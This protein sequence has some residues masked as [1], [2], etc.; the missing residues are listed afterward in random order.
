[1]SSEPSARSFDLGRSLALTFGVD[2]AD[3][4]IGAVLD[5]LRDRGGIDGIAVTASY[6]AATS[7]TLLA[8]F[9]FSVLPVDLFKSPPTTAKQA[10][11]ISSGKI[12]SFNSVRFA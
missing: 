10:L 9:T 6:H 2:L 1:M 5:N 4:G 3:E 7:T 12:I 8:P 11:A